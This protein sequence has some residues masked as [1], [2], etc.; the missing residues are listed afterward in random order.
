MTVLVTIGILAGTVQLVSHYQFSQFYNKLPPTVREELDALEN[1]GEEG[2]LRSMAIYGEY[3]DG[4]PFAGERLA[5]LVGLLVCLPIGLGVGFAVSRVVTLPVGSMAEAAKRI[6][7]GDFTVRAEPGRTTGEMAEMVNDFNR[8]TDALEQLECE[9]KA[10]AAA[11]SHELRTPLAVLRARLHALCDEVIAPSKTELAILLGQAEHL[12]RLVDDLHTL[13]MADAGRLSF[14]CRDLDWVALVKDVIER[15]AP[16]FAQHGITPDIQFQASSAWIRADSDR[17]VQVVSN[18]LDNALRYAGSGGWLALRMTV[19]AEVGI[20]ELSMSDAGPGLPEEV[21]KTLFQ[22]F[23]R[24][25]AAGGWPSPQSGSGLG[26]SIVFALVVG[27]GGQ[28]EVGTSDRGGT[29]FSI[30]MPTQAVH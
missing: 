27:Q 20:T 10:T 21:R 26:L 25:N 15:Y 24:A 29:R 9:R 11:V 13:S 17:M 6:A 4:D 5:L 7:L 19:D 16:G 30:R 8:M 1:E 22:R 18:L 3:W 12:S 23:S 14:H 2:S 28:I